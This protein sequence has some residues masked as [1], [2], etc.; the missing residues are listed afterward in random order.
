MQPFTKPHIIKKTFHTTQEKRTLQSGYSIEE[1]KSL[2][3]TSGQLD[4]GL[5]YLIYCFIGVKVKKSGIIVCLC[6]RVCVF[7]LNYILVTNVDIASQVHNFK[8]LLENKRNKNDSD[9]TWSINDCSKKQVAN[10]L[11]LED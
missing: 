1:A 2:E 6:V 9:V 3:N 5:I 11:D 10:I 7:I 4:P 8:T